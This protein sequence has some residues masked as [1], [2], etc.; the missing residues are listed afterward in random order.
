MA[1]A[2]IAPLSAPP[3]W[4]AF[5]REP[6]VKPEALQANALR[7]FQLPESIARRIAEI[8]WNETNGKGRA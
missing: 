2:N 1:G 6:K 8:H 4:A 5:E 3:L 7:R